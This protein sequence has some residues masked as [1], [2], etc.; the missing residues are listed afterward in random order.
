MLRLLKIMGE[1]LS[2]DFENGDFV[3]VSKIP[4]LF[5]PLAI[6]DVVAFYQPGYGLLIKLVK[7]VNPACMFSVPSPIVPTAGF[8]VR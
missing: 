1:S 8:S 6:G 3:I 7:G 4:F 5:S 2:P